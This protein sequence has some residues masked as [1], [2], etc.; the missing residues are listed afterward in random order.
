[1]RTRTFLLIFAVVFVS[2]MALIVF[3]NRAPASPPRLSFTCLGYTNGLSGER[4]AIVV[5]TNEDTSTISFGGR[6]SYIWFDSTNTPVGATSSTENTPDI[7]AGDSRTVCIC[8]P[9]HTVRCSVMV[10]VTRQTPVAR[11][12]EATGAERWRVPFLRAPAVYDI[13]SD[14]IIE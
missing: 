7:Q 4:F 9:P 14:Y 11:V 10:F 6:G 1:M 8:I 2:T 5:I 3:S 13:R 12:L